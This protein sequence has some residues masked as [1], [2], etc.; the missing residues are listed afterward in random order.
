MSALKAIAESV[1]LE[2][3]LTRAIPMTQKSKAGLGLQLLAGMLVIVALGFLIAAFH[4]WLSAQYT[5]DV[6]SLITAG[7]I[8]ALAMISSLAAYGVAHKRRIRMALFK[9]EMKNNIQTV[10][11]T[12]DDELGEHVRDNPVAA[13]AIAGVA[14]FLLADRVL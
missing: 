10:I 12:F 11:D 8:F 9:H 5:S 1:L 14:G 6:A 2:Q 7:A 4:A 13:L 3:V